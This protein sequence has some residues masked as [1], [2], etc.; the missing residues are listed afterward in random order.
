MID[1]LSVQSS[2]KCPIYYPNDYETTM[3][4]GSTTLL[5]LV[6]KEFIQ[7]TM[8]IR[9]LCLTD[10]R[11]ALSKTILHFEYLPPIASNDEHENEHC[12]PTMLTHSLIDFIGQINKRRATTHHDRFITV[13]CG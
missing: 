9:Q 8:I 3:K 7:D 13:H 11:E 4:I 2:P 10:T 1:S 12:L 6:E 5:K